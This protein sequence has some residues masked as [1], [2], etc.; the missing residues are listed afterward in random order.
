MLTEKYALRTDN[1]GHLVGLPK[2]A[3]NEDVEII[4]LRKGTEFPIPLHRPS[5]KLANQGAKLL[6]D[7]IAPAFAAEEWGE[8]FEGGKNL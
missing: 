4:V 8:L 2:L 5:P 3:P 1:Q 7:D 6:G